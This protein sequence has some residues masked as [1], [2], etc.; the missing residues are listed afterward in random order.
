VDARIQRQAIL[1]REPPAD[2]SVVL[3]EAV[4]VR[5][6]GGARVMS[7][8]LEHLADLAKLPNVVIQVLPFAAG[9]H[10]AM[11]TPYVILNFADAPDESIVYLENLTNGQ[12]LEEPDYVT[13]YNLVHETLTKMAL[14]PDQSIAFLRKAARDMK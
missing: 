6:V 4:L 7:Q 14:D 2:F 5:P 13:G 9:G 3:N 8:Q 1:H 12:V 11:T 10:P